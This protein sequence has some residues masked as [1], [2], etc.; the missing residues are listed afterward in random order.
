MITAC[1]GVAYDV[2]K[3]CFTYYDIFTPELMRS[4]YVPRTQEYVFNA[5]PQLAR[6]RE[7]WAPDLLRTYDPTC[8]EEERPIRHA[9]AYF[10]ICDIVLSATPNDRRG[11]QFYTVDSAIRRLRQGGVYNAF[12]MDGQKPLVTL[13]SP[14]ARQLW[15]WFAKGR[16]G[17]LVLL[18][19]TDASVRQTVSVVGVRTKGR[20]ILSGRTYDFSSGDCVFDLGPREACFVA[21]DRF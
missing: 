17:V 14:G 4:F 1:E 15:A 10:K 3:N 16:E 2:L 9:A 18:N 20:E 7:C 21:F 6:A 5:V 8:P 19:D 12:Y 11:P 13:S